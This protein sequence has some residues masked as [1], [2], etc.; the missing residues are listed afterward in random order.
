MDLIEKGKKV[1][2]YVAAV[3]YIGGS[4]YLDAR[5]G[6]L[7][8]KKNPQ[9][10]LENPFIIQVQCGNRNSPSY[11]CYELKLPLIQVSGDIRRKSK[12]EYNENFNFAQRTVDET[13]KFSD[14][15][16]VDDVDEPDKFAIAVVLA[17]GDTPFQVDWSTLIESN[18]MDYIIPKSKKKQR[19]NSSTVASSLTQGQPQI[20]NKNEEEEEEEDD[21]DDDDDD[22]VE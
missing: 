7:I 11:K 4:R 10:P 2:A 14:Y 17:E 22:N 6:F 8:D 18:I 9:T 15:N 19:T 16:T 13:S 3:K 20:N 12:V 5:K 21:D 1:L